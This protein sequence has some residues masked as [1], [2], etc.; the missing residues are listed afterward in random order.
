MLGGQR[1]EFTCPPGAGEGSM[2]HV[3][4]PAPIGGGPSTVGGGGNTIQPAQRNQRRSS[5][6]PG[7]TGAG[8]SQP[9][10]SVPPPQQSSAAGGAA[11]GGTRTYMVRVPRG[12]RAGQNFAASINGRRFVV[13][14]PPGI[15]PGQPLHI[16]V[17]AEGGGSGAAGLQAAANR[18][19]TSHNP[20]QVPPQ[21]QQTFMVTVPEGIQ[22]GQQFMVMAGNQ[23][24]TVTCPASCSGGSRVYV[25]VPT[26]GLPGAGLPGAG[27]N[28]GAPGMEGKN[29]EDEDDYE[30]LDAALKEISEKQGSSKSKFERKVG[31]DGKLHWVAATPVR[32]GKGGE[33]LPTAE[34]QAEQAAVVVESD[35][36]FGSDGMVRRM[37][38]SGA[39]SFIPAHEAVIEVSG[40]GLSGMTPELLARASALPFKKKLKWF[41]QCRDKLRV[42]WEQGHKKI[43]ITRSN[44]LYESMANFQRFKKEDETGKNDM[45]KTFRFQFTG[46]EGIDAG[47]L[48][49]EWFQVVSE[50][51]FNPDFGLFV[52]SGIGGEIVTINPQSGIAN[53]HHLDYFHFAGRMLGKA[54][55]DSQIVG[56]HLALQIY[57][58]LLATPITFH[59]LE[60]VD[61]DLVSGLKQLMDMGDVSSAFMDFSI[62]EEVY[63][64][65]HVVDLI[66]DGRNIDVD[67]DN[68]HKYVQ[69]LVRYYMLDRIKDQLS[70]FLRGF[71]D[72]IPQPLLSIFDHREIE[73]VLCGLPN[74]DKEDWQRNTLYAGQYEQKGRNHKVIK[75]FW[76]FVDT[77]DE[78]DAARLLQFSTGT[79]RVPVQGF[80]LL[81]GRDGD[82]RKFTITHI[83]VKESV[84]PKAVSRER[85]GRD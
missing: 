83:K 84:F 68:V 67:N 79:A 55:F 18:Q 85:V 22:P 26:G 65:T 25:R 29:A 59:D 78:S 39:L 20:M 23:R 33:N 19:R 38:K 72:V 58:H 80:K 75:W 11:G 15:S 1:H 17:P 66:P 74:I 10:Y 62:T 73:L 21:S 81:Q 9:F 77:L 5:A 70:S 43:R 50:Q 27:S 14:C 52:G 47:G 24:V 76:K 49:R 12:V 60:V 71:Y 42:P 30:V 46:E 53:E 45:H 2:V 40:T 51:L 41:R 7:G 64:A 32:E 36:K 16:R 31:D 35:G 28:R 3:Q 82:V 44:I 61:A 6:G 57:K 48:A 34:A 37:S 13:Q 69:A 54:F 8:G 56:C 63:G 4:G